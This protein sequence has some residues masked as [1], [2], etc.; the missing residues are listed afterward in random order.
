MTV[1]PLRAG[2]LLLGLCV[3][4]S[5]AGAQQG[6]TIPPGPTSGTPSDPTIGSTAAPASMSGPAARLPGT[7]TKADGAVPGTKVPESGTIGTSGSGN[8]RN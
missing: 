7:P 1:Q 2:L 5:A 3:L 6:E 8:S 4:P